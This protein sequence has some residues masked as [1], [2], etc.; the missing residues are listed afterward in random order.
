VY[1]GR[2]ASD[3]NGLLPQPEITIQP[4]TGALGAGGAD[5]RWGDY[6][7]M[8]VD[9]VDDCTFW[10]T[11]DYATT[12]R[13]SVIASFRFSDCATDLE[14][15]KTVEPA[16][17]NAGEE[18]VYTITVTNNGPIGAANVV[19]TDTLPAAFNYLA[20]TDT[21]SGV[22]VGD[23]GVLTCQLGTLAAGASR[24]FQIKGSIDPDLGGATSI[25]NRAVVSSAANESDP[26]DNVAVL[27]HLVNE[28]ADVRVTKLCKPD[29]F[30]APAGTSGVC[31]IFVTN[32]GPSAARLVNLV[33]THVS[34]GAFSLSTSSL[35][36]IAGATTVTCALGTI[37]PG[38][39]VQVDVNVTS[40]AQVDVNDVARATSATPDPNLGNNEAR[41]GLS[42]AASADLSITKSGPT[43]ATAGTQFTYILTVDN[44]GPSTAQNVVVSDELP[45]DVDFV[46][47][48]A[49]V[50]SFTAVNGTITWNLGTVAVADPAQTLHITVFV[51][52]DAT[53]SLINN[54]AV[55]STTSDPNI[56]NNLATWTVDLEASAGLTLTKTDSPDPVIAGNNLTYT[57]TVGNGGPSTAVDVVVTDTL[58]VGTT[59]VSAVGG[60]GTT[61]CAEVALGIVSCEVGDLDPGESETIFITV[62]VASSVPDGTILTNTAHAASPT[63][64]DGADA[65]AQTTV[66]ARADLWMEKTGTAPAGNPAGALIYTLT[67]HNHPGSAPDDTPTS[68]AGGPSDALDIVVSDPLPLTNKKLTVQFLTPGCTYN[69][70]A[71]LVTCTTA[72]V[73]FG[74][75]VVFSFQVQI[76]G[77]NGTITN[78]ATVSSATTDPNLNNNSDTV[79][80]VVQGGTGK[81]KRP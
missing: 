1:T 71:H 8:V 68:G 48:L 25:T 62:K 23:T 27:T 70:P 75:S 13:Q 36:C 52:P 76:Q 9:P 22:A 41:A 59:L 80:N 29:T 5:T 38:A 7:T 69:K 72:V 63:D 14:I 74:T 15:S 4:G 58:P 19:V 45:A 20:D 42:F 77:S 31:S 55:T 60:T 35:G 33:D 65:S 3:P 32:D 53:G 79:N 12:V 46:S 6:Y 54:A 81:G 67:V 44:A 39:T 37:Q 24:S 34:S 18:I 47:A 51:H 2:L 28:L 40:N 73:P 78:R 16:H 64:P 30:P 21:C 10:Y 56:A 26:A 49:S 11:G 43:D 61:A 17:P 66:I 57:L 50:G